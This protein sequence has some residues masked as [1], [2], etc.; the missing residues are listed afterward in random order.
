VS[1]AISQVDLTRITDT[2]K[3]MQAAS[4]IISNMQQAFN[5]NITFGNFSA[6]IVTQKFSGANTDVRITHSLNRTGVN[7]IPVNM[8]AAS[9]LYHGAGSD[10]ASS[11]VLRSSVANVTFTILLF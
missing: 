5:G 1:S 8:N 7:F 6:Q 9:I 3:F 10:N 4:T 11:V 2:T